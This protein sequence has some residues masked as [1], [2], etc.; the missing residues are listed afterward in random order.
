MSENKSAGELWRAVEP[1]ILAQAET[2][3]TYQR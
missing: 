3:G 2:V 1:H